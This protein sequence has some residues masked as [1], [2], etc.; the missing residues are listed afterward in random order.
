MKS[1]TRILLVI[2]VATLAASAQKSNDA[3][4]KQIKS[5]KADKSITLT[6]DGNSS[7]IMATA[8]NFAD[9]EAKRAKIQAMNFG[10]AIFYSGKELTAAIDTFDFAFWVL[11]KKPQ[12]GASHSWKITLGGVSLDVGDALYAAKP[13]ENM[14]YLNFKL[15]RANLVKITTEKSAVKFKLGTSEF[16]FTPSQ[17]ELFKNLLAITDPA[18]QQNRK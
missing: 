15:T 13:R 8:A 18:S 17:L 4:S 7:K 10:M 16:T 2:F 11:T 12:F 6:Y 3:I 9:S 1:I 5:L 14:E